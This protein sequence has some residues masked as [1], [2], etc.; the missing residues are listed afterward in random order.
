MSSI[1]FEALLEANGEG[2]AW[3]LIF[4]PVDCVE[5]F[6]TKGRLSVKGTLNGFPFQ[7]SIFP[8]GDGTH[9]LM[10]NKQM[11]EGAKAKV[12]DTLAVTM[13]ADTGPRVVSVPDDLQRALSGH[14]EASAIFEKLAY[15][16][17]KEY[18]E[19][20][21]QAKREETRAGR[22]QKT[23]EMLVEGKRVKS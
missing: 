3:P 15:S 6:G 14:A 16:H 19:W 17:K 2:G 12:G 13:E 20:I 11:R 10:I 8:N 22:I 23:V 9:H 21:E 18:V 4:I 1:Q 7:S 5:A